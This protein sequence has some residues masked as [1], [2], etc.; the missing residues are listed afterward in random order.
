MSNLKSNDRIPSSLSVR[1][2]DPEHPAADDGAI[3]GWTGLVRVDGESYTWMGQ[4]KVNNEFPQNV[5]QTSFEYTSQ[6]STF[7][8]D[9][10]GKVQMNISFLSPIWPNDLKR[11][12]IIGSYLQVTVAS[13]DGASHSVQ[14]YSDITAGKILPFPHNQLYVSCA[15]VHFSRKANESTS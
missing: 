12:S 9:V 5:A 11:A 15:W 3:V 7:I 13:T 6:R 14:C 1:S 2:N 4:P 8:M 10:A